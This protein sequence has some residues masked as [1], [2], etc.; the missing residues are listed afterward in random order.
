MQHNIASRV[1]F[2]INYWLSIFS[3]T[4][5]RYYFTT[6]RRSVETPLSVVTL[7]K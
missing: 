4:Y 2:F 7:T 3:I 1:T 5:N 6:L